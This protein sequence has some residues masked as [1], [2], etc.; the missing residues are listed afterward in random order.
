MRLIAGVIGGYIY[1]SSD[2]GATWTQNTT[3]G[4]NSWRAVASSAD[5]VKVVA[6]AI[7]GSIFTSSD[8]GATWTEQTSVDPQSWNTI[9]SSADG[10]KLVAAVSDGSIFTSSNSGA[11]WTEQTAAGTRNWNVVASSADGTKIVAEDYVYEG[12]AVYESSDSGITWTEI[13][14]AGLS[15]W[16]DIALSAD[17]S[18]IVSADSYGYV[19]IGTPEVAIPGGTVVT[20]PVQQPSSSPLVTPHRQP[21]LQRTVED[22]TSTTPESDTSQ[23]GSPTT[24]T[25]ILNE[26]GSKKE[27]DVTDTIRHA[28][29]SVTSN[30]CSS[31]DANSVTAYG[32]SKV[33]S[34][35]KTVS[36]VGGIGYGL[37]CA[38]TGG[39]ALTTITL[40]K[41]Y[42][43]I[44]KLHIY[45][46]DNGRLRDITNKVTIENKKVDGQW[47]TLLSYDMTDGGVLDEDGIVNAK[48]VDPIYVGVDNA[49][50][51]AE[52]IA[53]AS[54]KSADIWWYI[55]GATIVLVV[56]AGVLLRIRQRSA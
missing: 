22:T 49:A 8:A 1:T 25:I 14:P 16:A 23:L 51:T 26:P 32:P 5:G 10:T 21:V 7:G 44:A 48:I 30:T 31:V 12:S 35:S 45:K 24:T 11:T 33:T 13:T 41:Y 40:G 38:V 53:P 50:V 6:A 15:V 55:G 27:D 20:P 9:A 36:I 54:P 28:T 56:G 19:Y 37:S 42:P 47:R 34:P 52:D 39:S 46:T 4:M 2:A 18:Q 29:L 43:D 3:L 17:G